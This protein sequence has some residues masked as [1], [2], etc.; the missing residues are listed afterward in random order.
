M[1]DQNIK[2]L[3]DKALQI[4]LDILNAIKVTKKGSDLTI[5][6]SGAIV[7]EGLNS[8]KHYAQSPS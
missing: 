4:R 5:I 6:A 2:K 7:H 1:F 3:E 8:A